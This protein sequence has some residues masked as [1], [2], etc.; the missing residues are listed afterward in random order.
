MENPT[1]E[2]AL[3][4]LLGAVI[5]VNAMLPATK[6]IEDRPDTILSGPGGIDS[7]TLVNL[8]VEL[9]SRIED[10]FDL[11]LTLADGIDADQDP[12]QTIDTLADYVASQ[13]A[14]AG[15]G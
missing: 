3:S 7:L 14:E 11:E 15:H 8:V 6:R 10:Q 4:L 12:F 1:K 5:E 13:L 9:E 2:K